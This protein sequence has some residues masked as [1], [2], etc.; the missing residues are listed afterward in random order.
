MWS[1]EQLY[2]VFPLHCTLFWFHYHK[3][4]NII[5]TVHV[6]RNRKKARRDVAGYKFMW[7]HRSKLS[8][9]LNAN[10]NHMQSGAF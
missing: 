6:K 3:K 5:T 7:K 10:S 1:Y 2:F 9:F 4:I 8:I